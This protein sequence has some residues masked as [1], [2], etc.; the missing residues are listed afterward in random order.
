MKIIKDKIKTCTNPNLT[1]FGDRKY[2]KLI[3]LNNYDF[4]CEETLEYS[5]IVRVV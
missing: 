2:Y 4:S 5:T 1:V 3:K